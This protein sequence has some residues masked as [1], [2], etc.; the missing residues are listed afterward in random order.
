VATPAITESGCLAE[1]FGGG[2]VKSQQLSVAIA[3]AAKRAGAAYFDA[4]PYLT[5][6]PIDGVHYTPEG[7]PAF[8]LALADAFRHQ[9]GN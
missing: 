8:G 1:M 3:A 6:S 9:F 2:A 7:M 5:V 4:G